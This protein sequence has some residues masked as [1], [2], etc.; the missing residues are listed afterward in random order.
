MCCVKSTHAT[1]FLP[2]FEKKSNPPTPFYTF[3]GIAPA[4]FID[5]TLSYKKPPVYLQKPWRKVAQQKTM[6]PKVCSH[7]YSAIAHSLL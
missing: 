1:L 3:G 7:V 4:S 2:D 6:P 5:K